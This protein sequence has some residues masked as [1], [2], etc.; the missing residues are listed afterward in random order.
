MAVKGAGLGPSLVESVNTGP[1]SNFFDLV[2]DEVPLAV[3][4]MQPHLPGLNGGIF[5]L[6]GVSD[7]ESQGVFPDRVVVRS[8]SGAVEAPHGS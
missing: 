7:N 3:S 6:A 8:F 4:D 2:T 5:D 1:Q